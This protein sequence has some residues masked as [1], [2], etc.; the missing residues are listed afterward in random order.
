MSNSG[1]IFLKEKNKN[2]NYKVN[3]QKVDK[4]A[5]DII[6]EF[7]KDLRKIFEILQKE[8]NLSNPF[9]SSELSEKLIKKSSDLTKDLYNKYKGSLELIVRKKNDSINLEFRNITNEVILIP[10]DFIKST[11]Y[12]EL[13]ENFDIL[14]ILMKNRNLDWEELSYRLTQLFSY[15]EIK[16][17]VMKVDKLE[18][19]RFFM[20]FIN[21][22]P[23]FIIGKSLPME[24]KYTKYKPIYAK[25]G[26]SKTY[27]SVYKRYISA[28]SNFFKY[29]IRINQIP[30]YLSWNLNLFFCD[31]ESIE[32]FPDYTVV[33]MYPLQVTEDLH[34]KFNSILFLMSGKEVNKR[35]NLK[36]R[37]MVEKFSITNNFNVFTGKKIGKKSLDI[38]L[39]PIFDSYVEFI[40]N[41]KNDTKN[42]I[43]SNRTY[44]FTINFKKNYISND[45]VNSVRTRNT[46]KK[47]NLK[48]KEKNNFDD[49][50]ESFKNLDPN[51]YRI[52][53][54]NRFSFPDFNSLENFILII[55]KKKNILF[56]R[57]IEF[58]KSFTYQ[59]I[60]YELKEKTVIYGYLPSNFSYNKEMEY[61]IEI[62]DTLNTD[63]TF[64][65]N[66][67]G[68]KQSS[69]SIYSLPASSQFSENDYSWEFTKHSLLQTIE[70]KENIYASQMQNELEN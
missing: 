52:L 55:S 5:L 68:F 29:N 9:K 13:I 70:Q 2:L 36:S 31:K 33:P 27:F 17:N 34:Q 64:Q 15:S 51:P 7:A 40:D 50:Y 60:F 61:I 23:N 19:I 69:L 30:N 1:L 38:T 8:E 49:L 6:F 14:L 46:I 54:K 57:T 16:R 42:F 48:Y 3:R 66:N 67:K 63:Y 32:Q 56:D 37:F 45:S 28:D 43:F 22:Y 62:L 65:I 12:K 53:F 41:Y 44:E 58:F 39:R 18:K 59:T 10:R 35:K 21:E 11:N 20:K 24:L 47:F 26:R 25:W 4:I